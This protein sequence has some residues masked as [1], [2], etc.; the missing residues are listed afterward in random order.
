MVASWGWSDATWLQIKDSANAFGGL[1]IES[2]F[3]EEVGSEAVASM[4]TRLLKGVGL[5]DVS[6][7]TNLS[8]ERSLEASMKRELSEQGWM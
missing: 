7:V 5:V 1:C 4:R 3:L 2:S 6:I 8:L